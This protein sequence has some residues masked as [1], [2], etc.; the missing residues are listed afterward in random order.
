MSLSGT[1]ERTAIEA[2]SEGKG[3]VD[4]YVDRLLAATT[5]HEQEIDRLIAKHLVN[6]SFERIGNID[7]TILRLA[8]CEMCYFDDIPASVSIN[9]AVELCRTFSDEQSRKFVNGVLSSIEKEI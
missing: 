6:W 9:E 5:A 2:A 3:S 8:V 7:K 1:D 4:P